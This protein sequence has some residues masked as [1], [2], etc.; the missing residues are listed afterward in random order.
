M[1]ISAVLLGHPSKSLNSKDGTN[2]W[3]TFMYPKIS[4]NKITLTLILKKKLHKHNC[5]CDTPANSYVKL[6]V[7]SKKKEDFPYHKKKNIVRHSSY[8]AFLTKTRLK[9]IVYKREHYD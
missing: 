2:C 6:R 3:N 5:H 8:N 1:L 9:N 4:Q 7:E